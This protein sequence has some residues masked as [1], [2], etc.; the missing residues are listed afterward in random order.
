MRRLGWAG[1]RAVDGSAHLDERFD[2]PRLEVATLH[3]VGQ[4]LDA[5]FTDK[6]RDAP[7][8]PCADQSRAQDAVDATQPAGG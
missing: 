1:G 7:T 8:E 3:G 2:S 4:F 6:H 5:I